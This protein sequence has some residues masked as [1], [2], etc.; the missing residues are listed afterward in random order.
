MTYR[1]QYRETVI[2]HPWAVKYDPGMKRNRP[3][4]IVG[5]M[6]LDTEANV[7]MSVGPK[8]RIKPDQVRELNQFP[9]LTTQKVCAVLRKAGIPVAVWNRS[10]MVRGWGSWSSG[11]RAQYDDFG[12]IGIGYELNH[13]SKATTHDVE[14][15]LDQAVEAMAKAG[16]H[17][18]DRDGPVRYF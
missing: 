14:K 17:P 18:V 4:Q 9:P 3:K 2:N 15:R 1:Y 8:S 13:W 5:A 7:T 11:V 16:I 10:G 6:I 12:R